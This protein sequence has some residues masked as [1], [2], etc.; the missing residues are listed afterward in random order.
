V[1]AYLDSDG[2]GIYSTVVGDSFNNVLLTD[3]EGE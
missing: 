2:N 1:G 3:N